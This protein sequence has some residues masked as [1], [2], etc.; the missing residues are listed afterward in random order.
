MYNTCTQ[1]SL[2]RKLYPSLAF[3]LSLSLSL[4]LWECANLECWEDN[5]CHKRVPVVEEEVL[6]TD[7]Q[8]HSDQGNV[9]LQHCNKQYSEL[10]IKSL[11]YMYTYA[12]KLMNY[13]SI[14]LG[15]M[16]LLVSPYY[17]YPNQR[18]WVYSKI[19]WLYF[20]TSVSCQIQVLVQRSR[21]IN[22]QNWY[23]VW[24]PTPYTYLVENGIQCTVFHFFTYSTCTPYCCIRILYNTQYM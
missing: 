16:C 12:S 20:V 3:P 19:A 4:H 24:K 21:N 10:T 2:V 5:L 1:A 14:K 11:T 6:L 18:S 22:M 17:S 23:N 13:K 8:Q 7:A 9:C 15:T